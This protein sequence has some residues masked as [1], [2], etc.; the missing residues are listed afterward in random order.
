MF[1][2]ENW[3]TRLLHNQMPL[4]MQ[5]RLQRAGHEIIIVPIQVPSERPAPRRPIR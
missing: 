2:R 5:R 3:W 4:A 1:A